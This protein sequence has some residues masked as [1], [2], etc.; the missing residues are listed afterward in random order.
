MEESRK[1]KRY[2]ANDV[3]SLR[4]GEA[5][6]ECLLHDISCNGVFV[7]TVARPAIGKEVL[8]NSTTMGEVR[9]LV[10]RHAWD[11]VGLEILEQQS[12]VAMPSASG[13]RLDAQGSKGSS[14]IKASLSKPS[15]KAGRQSE[16]FG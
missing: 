4:I 11:G 16:L 10:V 14:V 8:L 15:G 13:S 6:H 9:A 1:F 3:A 7:E 2:R 5:W 12:A